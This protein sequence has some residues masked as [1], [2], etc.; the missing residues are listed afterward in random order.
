MKNSAVDPIKQKAY[1]TAKII[2]K[3][4]QKVFLMNL[5]KTSPNWP[6]LT[7]I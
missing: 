4:K 6:E 1:A 5:S 2:M 3:A 7:A